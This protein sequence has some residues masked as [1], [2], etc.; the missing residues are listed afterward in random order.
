M[1]ILEYVFLEIQAQ[2]AKAGGFGSLAHTRWSGARRYQRK[3][4]LRGGERVE[5]F[6]MQLSVYVFRGCNFGILRAEIQIGAPMYN[7]GDIKGRCD[8]A[9]KTRTDA[10]PALKTRT[11]F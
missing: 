6:G 4:K 1:H 10:D 2:K 9:L 7:R 3:G 8:P 5:N 11:E